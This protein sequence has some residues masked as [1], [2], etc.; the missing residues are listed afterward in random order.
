MV[1]LIR[2]D[3][4]TMGVRDI[5][6]KLRPSGIGRD[7]FELICREEGLLSNPVK[8]WTR[9]TNSSG[10]IRFPDLTKE[11]E[12]NKINQVW[13]SDITYFELQGRFYYITFI[14][15]IYTK[16]I[17]GHSCSSSLETKQ[18]TLPSLQK[19][20][21]N[22]CMDLSGLILHSDGGGQ[23]YCTEFLKLT[24]QHNILNSMCEYAWENG[25][26]ERLNGVIKNNYLKHRK[27]STYEE[28]RKEVDRSVSLY[29]YDKPHKALKRKTPYMFETEILLLQ[30]QPRPRMTESFNAKSQSSGASSPMTIEATKTSESRCIPRNIGWRGL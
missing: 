10:V 19:A 2:E 18:T 26:V 20:I 22:R 13:Q 14:Q 17:V 27:I 8:N 21:K 24:K 12:I 30:Q 16:M 25:T 9:T 23:Y 4:P 3:H 1:Q 29:N 6:F 15:D 7:G 28:L 11:L 5:Y